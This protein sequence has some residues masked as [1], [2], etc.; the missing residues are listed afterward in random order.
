MI[1]FIFLDLPYLVFQNAQ[2]KSQHRLY[3]QHVACIIVFLKSL[4]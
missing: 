1:L 2:W 3:I 4:S